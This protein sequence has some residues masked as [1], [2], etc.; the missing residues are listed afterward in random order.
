MCYEELDLSS[1]KEVCELL[2]IAVG[3]SDALLRMTEEE[4]A[5]QWENRYRSAIEDAMRV[6]I[7]WNEPRR[8][9]AQQ[10]ILEYP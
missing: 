4:T 1:A 8:F 7:Q 3:D 5:D 2:E 10:K 9:P 6:C